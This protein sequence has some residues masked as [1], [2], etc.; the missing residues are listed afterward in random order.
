MPF[1]T[2]LKWSP[3]IITKPAS[4]H[5]CLFHSLNTGWFSDRQLCKHKQN[6]SNNPWGG[7]EDAKSTISIRNI[8]LR[9]S[10]FKKRVKIGLDRSVID[11][12]SLRLRWSRGSML[13]FG[14]QVRGF[15]PDRSR[16]IFRAKNSSVR[17]PS[18]G[19]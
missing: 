15:T 4:E 7:R 10:Q 3:L 12:H 14:T 11:M 16:R 1:L 19:N 17:F 2:N 18:E 5:W 8:N 6:M 9:R 13:A